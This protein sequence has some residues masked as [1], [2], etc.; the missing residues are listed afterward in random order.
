MADTLISQD[1]LNEILGISQNKD[2]TFTESP[3]PEVV[4][5]KNAMQETTTLKKLDTLTTEKPP[6]AIT[7]AGPIGSSDDPMGNATAFSSVVAAHSI[8]GKIFNNIQSSD[9]FVATPIIITELFKKQWASN[10]IKSGQVKTKP[11]YANLLDTL[12]SDRIRLVTKQKLF[13]RYKA[14]SVVPSHLGMPKDVAKW[15]KNHANDTQLYLALD[16]TSRKLLG[17]K[18][19]PRKG[20][21]VKAPTKGKIVYIPL[22][23]SLSDLYD[24]IHKPDDNGSSPY[25]KVSQEAFKAAKANLLGRYYNLYIPKGNG[26]NLK[27]RNPMMVDWAEQITSP[28]SL[29][30]DALK[31]S[32]FAIDVT[33]PTPVEL[34]T[35]PFVKVNT[36]VA[37][38]M[39]GEL[40]KSQY[41]SVARLTTE[42]LGKTKPGIALARSLNE[43]RFTRWMLRW[44]NY[45][46]EK[47]QEFKQIQ[48]RVSAEIGQRAVSSV[49][50]YKKVINIAEKKGLPGIKSAKITTVGGDITKRAEQEIEPLI[51]KAHIKDVSKARSCYISPSGKVYGTTAS[52]PIHD[53]IAQL[54]ARK[55]GNTDFYPSN[56]IDDYNFARISMSSAGGAIGIDIKNGLTE[57]QQ[58]TLKRIIMKNN[59]GKPFEHITTN[60][61]DPNIKLNTKGLEEY[62]N[63]TKKIKPGE[64]IAEGLTFKTNKEVNSFVLHA[65]EGNTIGLGKFVD[66]ALDKT[67]NKP[68]FN[69]KIGNKIFDPR[70]YTQIQKKFYQW[71][72]NGN[73]V[74][75]GQHL[76]NG[77]SLASYFHGDPAEFAKA[78]GLGENTIKYITPIDMEFI[79]NSLESGDAEKYFNPEV[80]GTLREFVG[81]TEKFKKDFDLLHGFERKTAMHIPHAHIGTKRAP[82]GIVKW[83]KTA[84]F[85]RERSNIFWKD[86]AS[87]ILN[88]KKNPS[89]PEMN[90]FNLL[91]WDS[92]D[93]LN[94]AYQ[95]VIEDTL[96]D[97]GITIP[98]NIKRVPTDPKKLAKIAYHIN[99]GTKLEK[100]EDYQSLIQKHYTDSER[101]LKE[102]VTNPKVLKNGINAMPSTI[103]DEGL[104]NIYDPRYN[105]KWQMYYP[106]GKIRFYLSKLREQVDNSFKKKIINEDEY[107]IADRGIR[108]LGESLGPDM[109]IDDYMEFTKLIGSDIIKK[110]VPEKVLGVTTKVK[111]YLVPKEVVSMLR[112]SMLDTTSEAAQTFYR[113]ARWYERGF[114]SV[115]TSKNPRF[116]GKYLPT[117][118]F[119]MWNNGVPFWRWGPRIEDGAMVLSKRGLVNVGGIK[120]PSNELHEAFS[121]AGALHQIRRLTK[122]EDMNTLIR[123]MNKVNN[124]SHFIR[125]GSEVLDI[126]GKA[127]GTSDDAIR[128]GTGIDYLG[129]EAKKGGWK[130]KEEILSHINEAAEEIGK[131]HYI[132]EDLPKPLKRMRGIAP[133]LSWYYH[134]APDM[135]KFLFKTDKMRR[136][137][138]G[139]ADAQHAFGT[140]DDIPIPPWL[141]KMHPIIFNK[142]NKYFYFKP[143]IPLFQLESF[144]PGGSVERMFQLGQPAIQLLLAIGG[145]Q[146]FPTF[147]KYSDLHKR[148]VAL[149]PSMYPF[150]AN[151][152]IRN[153]P[154]IQHKLGLTIFGDLKDTEVPYLAIDK[155]IV[156]I[157]HSIKG[158]EWSVFVDNNLSSM[159]FYVNDWKLKVDVDSEPEHLMKP[160]KQVGNI[161]FAM[162]KVKARIKPK[163]FPIG[164]TMGFV[165]E[166]DPDEYTLARLQGFYDLTKK[167][168]SV[169][170]LIASESG[171]TQLAIKPNDYQKLLDEYE[172]NIEEFYQFV[173][174]NPKEL[175]Q[176]I[177]AISKNL[178]GLPQLWDNI[179]TI[180]QYNALHY[181]DVY[182]G[183][184]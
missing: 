156:D 36:K 129:R 95:K 13:N 59:Y 160:G 39:A 171:K 88:S 91:A 50:D 52:E 58:I 155:R 42:A 30:R 32:A 120:I 153:N 98:I 65:K 143:P 76:A 54:I 27:I 169:S 44:F 119:Q 16:T 131:A 63:I 99:P 139:L 68:I 114:L 6:K 4:Q 24:W 184:H 105:M 113:A 159:K 167:L 79:I 168:K 57:A 162:G 182:M 64:S 28:N 146:T 77:G 135:T 94:V 73:Y 158:N 12:S 19:G 97:S 132:Y 31:A 166:Y 23:K 89:V 21:I 51:K 176:I 144:M 25:E 175:S 123:E 180:P 109:A 55:T 72:V 178:E 48:S 85:M 46:P 140:D 10:L 17:V 112:G 87:E 110:A 151:D 163:D 100:I 20:G 179:A 14:V 1:E 38:D 60:I 9:S 145:V 86:Y 134:M 126:P 3:P 103:L 11:E 102:A 83:K 106:H 37:T 116:W 7:A 34:L 130:T 111:P 80:L 154:E 173:K 8:I 121:K 75:V 124:K 84:T 78:L 101:I 47:V 157:W 61:I 107:N 15:K 41:K 177:D 147:S 152:K 70:K 138:R 56:L 40:T 161:S 125:K 49:K 164:Q 117:D 22:N 71:M 148:Y 92:Q 141:E 93:S 74:D 172:S 142:G 136:L 183:D 33:I 108:S 104:K 122:A 181:P 69:F 170:S 128:L 150:I 82:Q 53:Q 5:E 18:H 127:L 62:S 81:N 67:M 115:F 2:T 43:S 66:S 133:F 149:P 165:R 26:E 137:Q 118:I 96:V 174:Y 45:A 35:S 29:T 90:I